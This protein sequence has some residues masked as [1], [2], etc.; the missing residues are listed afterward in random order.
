V[1]P[2]WLAAERSGSGWVGPGTGWD[3]L[4]ALELDGWLDLPVA[5]ERQGRPPAPPP[6]IRRRRP[7]HGA[8]PATVPEAAA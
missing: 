2:G 7:G 5:S 6:R 8:G 4:W 3:P 1:I